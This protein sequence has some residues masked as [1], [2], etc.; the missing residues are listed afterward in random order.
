MKR[1][2]D[3]VRAL[4]LKVEEIPAEAGAVHGLEFDSSFFEIEGWDR[5]TAVSHFSLLMDA[6]FIKAPDRQG[7]TQL[8]HP[9]EYRRR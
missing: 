4:L 3:L 9:T 2:I 8:A 6:G 7:L 5:D 1:D